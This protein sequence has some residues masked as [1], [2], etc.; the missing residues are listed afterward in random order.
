ML[1]RST[2]GAITIMVGVFLFFLLEG[3]FVPKLLLVIFFVFLTA[4]VA[5]LMMG[6]SAYRVGIKLWSKSTE[7]DLK[8]YMESKIEKNSK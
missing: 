4:P 3:I 2:L 8:E 6:R 5:G 7:D 1:F